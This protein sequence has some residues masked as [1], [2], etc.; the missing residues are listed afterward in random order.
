MYFREKVSR[1]RR[2]NAKCVASKPLHPAAVLIRVQDRLWGHV[3]HQHGGVPRPS[4]LVP[5]PDDMERQHF[6]VQQ[7]SLW[8]LE[9]KPLPFQHLIGTKRPNKLLPRTLYHHE[10]RSWVGGGANLLRSDLQRES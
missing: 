2:Q 6:A 5:G 10:D 1:K 4:T 9:L 3:D 7:A 8:W